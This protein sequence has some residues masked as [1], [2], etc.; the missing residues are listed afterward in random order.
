MEKKL[1]RRDPMAH[2]RVFFKDLGHM[3]GLLRAS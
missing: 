2:V 3:F 1:T